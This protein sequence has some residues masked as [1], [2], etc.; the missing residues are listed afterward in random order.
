MREW[1][2]DAMSAVL[3][4]FDGPVCSVFSGYPAP[5]VADELRGDLLTLGITATEG[6]R[7]SLDP[8]EVLR[9]TG[10]EHPE[11]IGEI[12]SA[13]TAAE[14]RAVR[15]AQPTPDA[16]R[17]IASA[18]RIGHPVAIVSNNSTPAI[19]DYLRK[20]DIADRVA[21]VAGRPFGKPWLM[22]P[23]PVLVLQAIEHLGVDPKRCVFVGDAVTDIQAGRTAGVRVIGYAK[24]SQHGAVLATAGPDLVISSMSELADALDKCA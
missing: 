4:D 19:T 23:S 18:Q 15:S 11:V 5:V 12:D 17:V 3:L 10:E 7:T 9:W 1:A 16:Y 8:L 20:H 21:V 2:L 6:I 14:R 13:L 22:K 24:T